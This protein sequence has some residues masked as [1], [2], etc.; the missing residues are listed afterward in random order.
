MD[1]IPFIARR[2]AM[3]L[4]RLRA[5]GHSLTVDVGDVYYQLA[6][7]DANQLLVEVS[8]NQFLPHGAALDGLAQKA[9]AGAGFTAPDEDWPNWHRT[10]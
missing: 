7:Y 2:I 3:Q 9:L 6:S 8:S 4:R 10:T 1:L 5:T